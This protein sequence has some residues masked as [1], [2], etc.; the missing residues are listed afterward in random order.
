M[1]PTLKKK[2]SRSQVQKKGGIDSFIAKELKS[3]S[4]KPAPSPK[5]DFKSPL[6]NPQKMTS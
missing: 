4:S 3:I 6:S 5:P 2:V 1:K